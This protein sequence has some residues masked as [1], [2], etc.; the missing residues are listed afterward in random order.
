MENHYEIGDS[1]NIVSVYKI[2]AK[3]KNSDECI[4]LYIEKSTDVA[5][6][7]LG[8]SNSHIYMYLKNNLTTLSSS[9]TS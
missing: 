5:Y 4:C 2:F 8:S 1:E 3:T 9:T 7:L 6:R